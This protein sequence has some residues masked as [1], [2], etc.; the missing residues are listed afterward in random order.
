[1]EMYLEVEV[2][3]PIFAKVSNNENYLVTDNSMTRF[4]ITLK[5]SVE[6][7]LWAI[8]NMEGGEI[9]VPKIPSYNIIDLVKAFNKNPKIKII[10]I[11][12]EKNYEEM[13]SI[14]EAINTVDLGKYYA[15]LNEFAKNT[16]K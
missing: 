3:L 9:F 15:I 16:K 7:V 12:P 11:R 10:G 1:M 2:L 6:M 5:Q 8:Q 13:I 14:S 4:N